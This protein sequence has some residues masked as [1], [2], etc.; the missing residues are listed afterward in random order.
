[1]MMFTFELCRAGV[2]LHDI[3]KMSNAMRVFS[4][5]W[6]PSVVSW[7]AGHLYWLFS[8]VYDF[9]S[10]NDVAD[11]PNNQLC[12]K[13]S[14]YMHVKDKLHKE[15]RGCEISDAWKEEKL[16]CSNHYIIYQL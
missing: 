9:S 8:L 13:S 12:L 14:R 16:S 11:E 6:R 2:C 15:G 7:K 10:I 3:S 4:I 5:P 1:M